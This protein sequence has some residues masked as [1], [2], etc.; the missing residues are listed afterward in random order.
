MFGE[1]IDF[2]PTA[3]PGGGRRGRHTHMLPMHQAEKPQLTPKEQANR[4][5]N[6]VGLDP[7]LLDGLSPDLLQGV[8]PQELRHAMVDAVAQL[9]AGKIITVIST[10]SLPDF[11]CGKIGMLPLS[12]RFPLMAEW[13]GSGAKL[14]L[15][16]PIRKKDMAP[17]ASAGQFIS[18]DS[19][20]GGSGSGQQDQGAIA[21]KMIAEEEALRKKQNKEKALQKKRKQAL[22]DAYGYQDQEDDTGWQQAV[23]YQQ[24]PQPH[25]PGAVQVSSSFL[26]EIQKRKSDQEMMEKAKSQE[27]EA[28]KAASRVL[29][30]FERTKVAVEQGLLAARQS[31][32]LLAG[33]D[34]AAKTA[35]DNAQEPENKDSSGEAGAAVDGA[36]QQEGNEKEADEGGGASQANRNEGRR[37]QRPGRSWRSGGDQDHESWGGD[38]DYESW[39]ETDPRGRR[40]DSRNDYRREAGGY[41]DHP[42]YRSPGY[43]R[44][45]GYPPPRRERRHGRRFVDGQD[46]L[47]AA[48]RSRSCG[49][50]EG[51]YFEDDR[52]AGYNRGRRD[53]RSPYHQ[54]YDPRRGDGRYQEHPDSRSPMQYRRDAG[55]YRRRQDSRSPM[56]GMDGERNYRPRRRMDYDQRYGDSPGRKFG[57]EYEDQEGPG[58][59]PR[60]PLR[61]RRRP[62]SADGRSRSPCGRDRGQGAD[63]QKETTGSAS[64]RQFAEKSS[65][66]GAQD[67]APPA[68]AAP[69][70]AF[71]S[72]P[73]PAVPGTAAAGAG[74]ATK[75]T[76]VL[77]QLACRGGWAEYVDQNTGEHVYKNV[78]TGEMTKRKPA[79]FGALITDTM[80]QRRLAWLANQRTMNQMGD[81]QGLARMQM[82]PPGM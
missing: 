75:P 66:P 33:S 7:K 73:G 51:G 58:R 26:E 41:Q 54:N 18:F 56:Q 55:P 63:K 17:V 9:Q 60:E 4:L 34:S 50:G 32:K 72:S 61:R 74:A 81:M 64:G 62:E 8:G 23:E 25:Q 36:P 82:P 59:R 80:N 2:A 52:R 24:P 48:S 44:G 22:A 69:K 71:S 76:P 31:V 29:L 57:R 19:L 5:A 15:P 30:N 35:D 47:Y 6:N 79:E 10:E 16:K 38:R 53:S 21:A 68:T 77:R 78:L 1:C 14:L 39:R 49:A 37:D 3:G 40:S 67:K 65:N 43:E 28:K 46:R 13:S 70:S 42:R 12:T 45:D 11:L 27:A 20:P